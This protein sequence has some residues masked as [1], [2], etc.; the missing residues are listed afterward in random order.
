MTMAFVSLV[1]VQ[2]FMAYNFRSDRHSLLYRPFANKWLNLAVAWELLPLAAVLYVPFMQAAFSTQSL[3][4]AEWA[5]ILIAAGTIFP[6]MELM[7]WML[8]RGRFGARD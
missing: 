4:Y 5:A 6:V 2:F 3:Q 1:L 8:R 7:K